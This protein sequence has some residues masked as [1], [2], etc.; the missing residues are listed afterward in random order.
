MPNRKVT[1]NDKLEG[2]WKEPVTATSMHMTWGAAKITKTFSAGRDEKSR[3]PSGVITV[4]LLRPA[5]GYV[6]EILAHG[7]PTC[8]TLLGPQLVY[9]TY[10]YIATCEGMKK[11]VLYA[12]LLNTTCESF[13]FFTPL[14]LSFNIQ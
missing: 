12:S 13:F 14:L 6:Q 9:P 4:G 2:M 5:S 10:Y 11:F 7:S 1:V 8:W 3:L